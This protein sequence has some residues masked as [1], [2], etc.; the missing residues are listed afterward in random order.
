MI[1]FRAR[2]K[3]VGMTIWK[4]VLLGL[5]I[6][7]AHSLGDE[8]RIK[9]LEMQALNLFSREQISA[10][11]YR[12]PNDP[13]DLWVLLGEWLFPVLFLLGVAAVLG[14][15]IGLYWL[16]S[17]FSKI[18][19]TNLFRIGHIA[20]IDGGGLG[21]FKAAPFMLSL[22]HIDNED[23]AALGGA[24]SGFEFEVA[25]KESSMSRP[26]SPTY[27]RSSPLASARSTDTRN[28]QRDVDRLR[29]ADGKG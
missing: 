24:F 20:W 7:Y 26:L 1:R 3:G 21:R 19:L 28:L 25:H 9:V 27:G 8:E 22:H 10:Q 16:I 17:R 11:F 15:G 2:V 12:S 18:K 14:M 6:S 23:V 5:S 4:R 13:Q 29:L